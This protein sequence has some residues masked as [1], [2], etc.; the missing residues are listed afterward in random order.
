VLADER[1]KTAQN[2]STKAQVAAQQALQEKDRGEQLRYIAEINAAVRDYDAGNIASARQ[3]LSSLVPADPKAKDRRHFEWYYL[4]GLFHQELRVFKGH[5]GAV[6]SLAFSANSRTLASAGADGT[7]RLWNPPVASFST[8][9]RLD[10]YGVSS[11][12]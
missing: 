12:I 1:A 10:G 6:M 2:E 4:D 7:I 5:E 11:G 9:R 8:P 3:R